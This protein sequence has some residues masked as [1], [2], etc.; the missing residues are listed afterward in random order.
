MLKKIGIALA[1]TLIYQSSQS[2]FLFSPSI[3]HMEHSEE[4][5]N[6]PKQ[7]AKMTLIDLRLG[8]L[9]DFGLYLGGLYSLQDYELLTDSSDS[10]F[11]P[12]I[13]YFNS[14]FFAALTYYVY[15]ER[16]LTNGS[17]KYSDVSGFQLDF[18]YS[19]PVAEDILIGP[20]LT[21]HDYKF[22][23]FQQNGN[24]ASADY[25]YSGLTPYFNLTFLF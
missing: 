21:F 13:G 7:T 19:V 6:A 18:S 11:G 25:K 12:T 20:Q 10:F 4:N 17:G 15:G 22:G 5:G 8:Y 9:M 3:T 2:A 1:F 14:G 23:D 24:S 16:D